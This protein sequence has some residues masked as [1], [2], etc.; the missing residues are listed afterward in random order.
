MFY[1][2]PRL[3]LADRTFGPGPAAYGRPDI[4]VQR[5]KPPKYTMRPAC[6]EGLDRT[7]SPG[8]AMYSLKLIPGKTSPAYSMGRKYNEC[9]TPYITPQ[10]MV[11][12]V[13]Q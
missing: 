10:D 12:C 7:V 9:F 1:R 4:E 5:W 6:R 13:K 11:P 8:P 3:G 2:S